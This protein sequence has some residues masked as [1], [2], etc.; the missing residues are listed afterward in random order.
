VK[1]SVV[2]ATYHR[3]RALRR[4]IP[5]VLEQDFPSS[6]WEVIVVVDGSRDGSVEYLRSLKPAC[7]LTII[8]QANRGQPAARNVGVLSA[9]GDLI[10]LLD[11]DIICDSKLVRTH[12]SAHEGR[13]SSIVVGRVL[14][15]ADSPRSLATE[16]AR[17]SFETNALLQ[18][19]VGWPASPYEL[20]VSANCSLPRSL[21]LQVGGC[22]ENLK[23]GHDDDLTIRLW[24]AGAS[25]K[26]APAALVWQYYVKTN[27]ELAACDGRVNGASE[28]FLCRKH[29]GYR[30]SSRLGR[31][32]RPSAV[33]RSCA[34]I[35]CH[36]PVSPELLLRAPCW[37]SEKLMSVPFFRRT[38]IRLLGRRV[39]ISVL[40]AAAAEAGSWRTLKRDLGKSLPVLAYHRVG[41]HGD[42]SSNGDLTVAPELFQRQMQW[43]ARHG[44][45]GIRPSQWLAWCREGKPLP[46]RPVLITFDDGCADIADNALP[47][48]R[49]LG[50]GAAIYLVTGRLGTSR[51]GSAVRDPWMPQPMSVEQ[52]REL[53]HEGVV[54]F[55]SHSRTHAD[56]TRL[57]DAQLRAEVEGSADDLA[58]IVGRRPCSFA[59]PHGTYNA[60][61]RDRVARSYDIGLSRDGGLNGL[62][63]DLHVMRRVAVQPADGRFAFACRVRLGLPPLRPGRARA[64]VERQPV[65]ATEILV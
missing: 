61:V 56:L 19:R 45:V 4:T 57:G 63:T 51:N 28:L 26:S 18:D 34:W 11:D 36:S 22:D 41:R 7:K 32:M 16:E 12:V 60:A 55:G 52:I 17:D 53:A 23:R 46:E 3:L 27:R 6:D 50:F 65:P 62:A 13:D 8:Q 44:Y 39:A 35:S 15:S 38:G 14:V 47:V 40:R 21:F 64:D 1:L 9:A 54:E 30:P 29:P 25:F 20:W 24:N 37:A 42:L 33:I 5:T 48:L 31:L 2:I 58:R 49:R 59:Y 43:L 10:L